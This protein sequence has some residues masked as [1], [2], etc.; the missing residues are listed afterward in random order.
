MVGNEVMNDEEAWSASP[1][2]RAYG[3]D[4]KLFMDRMVDEEVLNR[5]LPLIYA[6]QD[7]STLGGVE[8]DKNEVMKLTVDYLTCAE[9]ENKFGQSPIDIFGVNVESWCS[10]TQDFRYNP[11]GTPG[12]YYSLYEALRNSSVPI[13]FSEMGCP[14]T[15]FDRD[16]LERKT[17]E[18]TR[19]WKQLSIVMNEMADSWSGFIAY[20]YDA[21]ID[22]NMF[23]GGPWNGIDTLTP[24]N[25]FYNFKQ[26]LDEVSGET[27]HTNNTQDWQLP[28]RCSSVESELL[29]CCDLRLFNDDMMQ[30]FQKTVDV[31]EV[32][33]AQTADMQPTDT[34][35]EVVTNNHAWYTVAILPSLVLYL[36]IQKG[37]RLRMCRK[38]PAEDYVP[39]QNDFSDDNCTGTR[40]YGTI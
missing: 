25:D 21:V 19:D 36:V 3:R 18:G 6:A 39:L 13:I 27:L 37:R 20:T 11:D 5:T 22:F 38:S 15:Q 16:D 26:Q 2:L 35:S 4:L 7:S 12:S 8:M 24:T 9:K 1:C 23:S 31:V 30:S 40:N 34:A 32:P 33:K 28:R 14:H 29:S 17:K 10:S